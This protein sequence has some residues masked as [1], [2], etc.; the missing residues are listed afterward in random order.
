MSNNFE[1]LILLIPCYCPPIN[2]RNLIEKLQA[3][4]F[5]KIIVVND[6]SPET[7][8]PIFSSLSGITLL[9]NE[10]NEGKGHALKVGFKYIKHHF[11]PHCFVITCDDDGQHAP[12]DVA[13]LGLRISKEPPNVILLGSRKF[14]EKH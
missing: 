7:Y 4:G 12:N 5:T 3:E 10:R 6:G 13:R 1:H 9:H 8:N 11:D 2:F 14:N